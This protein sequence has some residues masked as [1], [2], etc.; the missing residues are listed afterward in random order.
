[1]ATSQMGS[2][3]QQLRKAVLEQEAPDGQLL[4]SFLSRRDGLA[5]EAL[6]RRHGSMI[7]NVCRRVLRHQQDA[8]D[9]FQATFLVFVR[10]AAS[11]V[12]REMVG[13]WLYGVA[14]QTALKANATAAKRRTREKQVTEMP[15]PAS[16]EQEHWTDLQP[17]LDQEISRLPDKYRVVVVLCDL[18][19]KTR[20][21]AAQQLGWPEGT[22]A[23]RLARARATLAKRLTQR[24]IVLSGG[25]LAAVLTQLAASACVPADVMATTIQTATLVAAGQGAATAAIPAKVAALT[26]G[27]VKAMLLSKLKNVAGFLALLGVLAFGGGLLTDHIV[28]GQQAQVE[29]RAPAI[30]EADDSDDLDGLFAPD[31][32]RPDENGPPKNLTNSIGMKFVWVPRGSFTM[33][34]PKEEEK[35]AANE[36]LHRVT[37]TR[38]EEHTSE[39]QSRFGISY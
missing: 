38:S 35:R 23:G 7:W 37:L 19:G 10:K 3:I 8:E 2:A 14:H 15:E 5:L 39:L 29:A 4:E 34:S 6:V 30:R 12:P 32:T 21:Q 25:S 11:I 33:G 36:T 28:A 31:R 20:A 18:D 24:G 13:N 9:A 22:V 17:I 27:V 16:A 26:E 1:M